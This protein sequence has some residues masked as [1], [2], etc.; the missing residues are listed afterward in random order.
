MQWH[1]DRFYDLIFDPARKSLRF[2]VVLP[3]VPLAMYEDFKRFVA[4]RRSPDVLEHRRI[5]PKRIRLFCS[6]RNGDISLLAKSKDGDLEYLAQK[7]VHLVQEVFQIFLRDGLYYEYMI[8]TFEV[9]R[10]QLA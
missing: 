1:K 7:L 9:D 6:R 2:E 5:D 10:D 8:E 4:S 3:N